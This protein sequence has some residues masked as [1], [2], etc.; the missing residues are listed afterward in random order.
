MAS[1]EGGTMVL[2]AGIPQGG[3]AGSVH[4]SLPLW[5]DGQ[6]SLPTTLAAAALR[7]A[8]RLLGKLL[9]CF[10]GAKQFMAPFHGTILA[11]IPSYCAALC[12]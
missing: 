8:Y 5:S 1:A 11:R 2:A 6:R 3:A 9:G 10:L 4:R 7:N 12:L